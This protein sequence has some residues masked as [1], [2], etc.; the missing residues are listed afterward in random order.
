MTL[1]QLSVRI[2]ALPPDAPLWAVMRDAEE[3]AKAAR[4]N[5]DLDDALRR[6]RRG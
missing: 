6:Y 2:R 5:A 1:R 4:L 3:T